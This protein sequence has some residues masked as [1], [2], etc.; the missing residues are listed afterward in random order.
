[1]DDR[2]YMKRALELAEKGIGRTNPNPLVGAVIVKN[3]K[4]IGEGYHEKY[5]Q[6]HAEVN[7]INRA[8]E[9]VEG[10][11]LYVNL[12]PCSHFGK[13][14]P[15]ADLIIEHKIS[16]V[17]I[18]SLDPN[19]KVAGMGVEKL[20]NAGIHVEVGMLDEWCK[21]LNEVFLH[22]ITTGTPYVVLKTAMSLDGKI[23]TSSGESKW[24]TGEPARSDVQRLRNQL[25][26]IMVGVNTVIQDDPLLTCRMEG[27]RNPRRI[28]VDSRLRIPDTSQVLQNQQ[29]N[30]TIIATIEEAGLNCPQRIRQL[31]KTG[32]EIVL[33]KSLKNKVDLEDLMEKLGQ[34]KIDSILLEGG[35]A[36]ND[37]AL[38]QG[39][40]Q[41]VISYIAP[42]II[43]G[44]E[45]KTPVGGKGITALNQAY[46][47]TIDQVE[48][49]G[50]DI[51]I[52]AYRR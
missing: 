5:G 33:C 45:S 12:E 8:V 10:A 49:I 15:C 35:A 16:R 44:E 24:I 9:N 37:S 3:G 50:Q 30:P 7:A 26:G 11:V 25:T 20:K 23:A 27:G 36:L 47:L 13:T 46:K 28:I 29:D 17:V 22:Y 48:P 2:Q 42:M 4:I 31:E 51:K 40:V 38:A 14:P 41:K 1:M 34:R 19:P 39:I 52:T 32:A 18:G 21:R 43:G 6:A